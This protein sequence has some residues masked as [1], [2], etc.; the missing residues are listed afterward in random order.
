M[1]D[2]GLQALK[3][4]LVG[5]G[6][7][8]GSVQVS[9]QTLHRDRLVC[10]SLD[11]GIAKEARTTVAGLEAYIVSA[12]DGGCLDV[13]YGV[14]PSTSSVNKNRDPRLRC[15]YGR[16]SRSCRPYSR[17]SYVCRLGLGFNSIG[18]LRKA[19]LVARRTVSK[20]EFVCHGLVHRT[21]TYDVHFTMQRLALYF[22]FPR[23]TSF[24]LQHS[25]FMA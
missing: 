24:H 19:H 9:P 7:P 4:T 18:F 20:A 2:G 15:A 11:L 23:R 16:R 25:Q 12:E 1:A 6:L 17:I 21:P 22:L 8:Y 13:Y 10:T 14:S 5:A 3:V